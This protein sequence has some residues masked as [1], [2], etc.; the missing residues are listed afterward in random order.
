MVQEVMPKKV[1]EMSAIELRRI[2]EPGRYSVGGVAGL[3]LEVRQTDSKSWI[4]RVV[5]GDK[6]RHFGLGSYP[7][8]SLARAREKAR[9]IREKIR[10]GIDP[11]EER[12]QRRLALMGKRTITFKEAVVRCFEKKAAEFKS[13]KHASD[14]FSSV[15]RFAFPVIGNTR[16]DEVFLTD[17]LAILD[18]IWTKKTETATRLRQRLEYILNWATVSGY[19]QGDNPARWKGHLDAILPKPTKIKKV[20]HFA[21]LPWKAIPDFMTDLRARK[22]ISARA[23]EFLILTAARSG[24]VRFATWDEIDFSARIW[25]IPANRMKAGKE[26]T[27]PLSDDA[28]KLLKAL[29][30]FEGSDYIFPAP[31]GGALCD[32]SLSALCRRM[33]VDAVPHGF[34][35]SFRDW[36][37][38][39]TNFAREVAEMALAHTIESSVEAAYRRGDLLKKRRHLMESWATFCWAPRVDEKVTAIN[40]TAKI[41]KNG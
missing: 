37:A 30:R 14:W 24:E 1:T 38:E 2:Q 26:H 12:R 36:C 11:A 18:P 21:A 7:E 22:G 15:E 32:M 5:V 41:A 33:K 9:E 29:P 6:R 27:V 23:L 39:S 40:Q 20:E 31:R 19:R 3:I 10:E 4:L 13:Q 34:R 25:A 35:S 8:I 17:I 16:V 28:L